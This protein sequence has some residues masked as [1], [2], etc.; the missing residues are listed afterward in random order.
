[1]FE[2]SLRS[3][4]LLSLPAFVLAALLVAITGF[5][6]PNFFSDS[7][8]TNLATRLLPLGLVALGQAMVLFA[9]RID[10][11]V[12][13]IMSLATAIMALTSAS[14]GWLS[15]PLALVAGLF[16]GVFTACGV[17]FLKINPLVMTLATAAIV[18]GITMLLLPSPGG[19]VDYA[20]YEALF[21]AERLFSA[22][23]IIT[24]V[25]FAVIAIAMNWSRLGRSIYAFGSD[26]R[27][28]F[29][30]GISALRVDLV[31]FGLSG[32]LAAGAG[33]VLSIRILSGDPLIGES[34]TL[35]AVSAAILGGVALQGGRGNAV[36]VFFAALSLVLIN[37]MFNLL[38]I[39]TSLQNIAKGLIF[40][41]ALVFFMRG[42]AEEN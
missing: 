36:G 17:N 5:L 35:D 3:N 8:L 33:I 11:S 34:Y 9:G 42:K 25:V 28:A 1:M 6:S 24:L 4:L 22:P 10:L 40:I 41:V 20:F 2:G 31:V 12:G 26:P 30:N 29:S 7:N 19:E 23:L 14:L 27:A 13:A 16:C 38:D 37:N 18:K 21:G 39:D 32:L 15:V